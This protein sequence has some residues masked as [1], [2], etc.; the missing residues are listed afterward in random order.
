MEAAV[1]AAL[2]TDLPATAR[3]VTDDAE[4]RAVIRAIID[5]LDGDRDYDEW[6]AGAPLAEITFV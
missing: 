3:P 4:R 2:A 6:V 5:E 1:R